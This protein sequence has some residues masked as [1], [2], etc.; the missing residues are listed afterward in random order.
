VATLKSYGGVPVMIW[1]L[2]YYPDDV[3]LVVRVSRMASSGRQQPVAQA[4]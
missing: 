3:V 1:F 2:E 4:S